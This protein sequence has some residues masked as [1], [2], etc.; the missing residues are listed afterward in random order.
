MKLFFRPV[1]R[2]ACWLFTSKCLLAMKLTIILLTAA[3]LQVSANGYAQSITIDMKN[4][5][6]QK[7]FA[8]IE[9]QTG[10]TFLYTDQMLVNLKTV[11]INVKNASLQSTLDIC[12]KE[13]PLSYTIVNKTIILKPKDP[14][15]GSGLPNA[16]TTNVVPPLD[17]SGKVTDKDG[18]PLEG[19][20][21]I[22]KRTGKGTQ[23]DINGTFILKVVNADD[24]I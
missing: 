17:I 13:L 20:S 21:V 10:Y 23:T 24:E 14:S 7:V 3:V 11:Q 5:P 16:E 6:V 19:A 15:T 2:A 8:E 4:A 22:I 1:C 18:K 12:F 9:K